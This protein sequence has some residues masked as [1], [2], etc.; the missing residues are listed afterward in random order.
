MICM[1]IWG[2]EMSQEHVARYMLP[3]KD[4]LVLA[5]VELAQGFLIN[6]RKEAGDWSP[7]ETWDTRV[8]NS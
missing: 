8:G 5:E 6:L 2:G 3:I 7:A 4:A 1:D